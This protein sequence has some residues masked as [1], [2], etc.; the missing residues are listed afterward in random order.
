[1]EL[2]RE[3][4]RGVD[5]PPGCRRGG[6]F[7]EVN[8]LMAALQPGRLGRRSRA[9]L[10]DEERRPDGRQ[11]RRVGRGQRDGSRGA[12]GHRAP[13]RGDPGE[14]TVGAG[15]RQRATWRWLRA[16]SRWRRPPAGTPRRPAGWRS[17]RSR[18]STPSRDLG[19]H[20]V[21]VA[22]RGRHRAGGRATSG[23]CRGSSGSRTPSEETA[24][25]PLALRAHRARTA[26][27]LAARGG[28]PRRRRSVCSGRPSTT[29]RPG[30]RCPTGARAALDLAAVLDAQGRAD[31]ARPVA[32]RRGR[33][34]GADRCLAWLA[35]SRFAAAR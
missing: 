31:E 28:R 3:R 4:Q 1:M 2:G 33:R 8:L 6:R 27:V 15:R 13:D 25:V 10:R 29:S 11:P 19:R 23:R 12:P 14:A 24:A 35:G 21:P 32:A 26:G 18:C 20:A 16:A 17:A 30:G 22:V 7:T 9:M 34:P 5:R